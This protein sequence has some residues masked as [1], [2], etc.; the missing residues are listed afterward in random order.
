MTGITPMHAGCATPTTTP[1][2]G[3]ALPGPRPMAPNPDGSDFGFAMPGP[4]M[5]IPMFQERFVSSMAGG[6]ILDKDGAPS[7]RVP[8]GSFVDTKDGT[9]YG[10]D[11]KKLNVPEGA[12][13]DFFDLPDVKQLMADAKA[14]SMPSVLDSAEGGGPAQKGTIVGG[15]WGPGGVTHFPGGAMAGCDMPGHAPGKPTTSV[16]GVSGSGPLPNVLTLQLQAALQQL[17]HLQTT[18]GGGAPS[19]PSQLPSQMMPP[20]FP[21]SAGG[22]MAGGL[23]S[24]VAGASGIGMTPGLQSSL[25]NLVSVLRELTAALATTTAGGA[26]GKIST[27]PAPVKPPVAPPTST[28]PPTTSPPST[29][30]PSSGSSST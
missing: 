20:G 4:G 14:G 28:M 22:V 5:A 19:K 25:V 12:T 15:Q 24:A 16:G 2:G 3:G 10:P 30:S 27:L 23:P 11:S 6:V 17:Q 29:T 13:V 1:V 26:P 7:G 8:E 9:I 21:V 18:M